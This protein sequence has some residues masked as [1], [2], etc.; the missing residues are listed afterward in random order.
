MLASALSSDPS[1]RSCLR[2]GCKFGQLHESGSAEPLMYCGDCGFKMCYTHSIAWHDSQT[3]SEY[4]YDLNAPGR[5]R[6]EEADSAAMI[7]GTSK[8]CPGKGCTTRIEKNEGCDHMTC[9]F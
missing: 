6:Q 5:R 4:D 1:F 2:P 7:A 9:M 8:E 3:C